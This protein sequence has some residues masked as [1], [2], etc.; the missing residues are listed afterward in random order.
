MTMRAIIAPAFDQAL[1][2]LVVQEVERP[3]PEA[4]EVLIRVSHAP[5]NPAD[6]MMI[7]GTYIRGTT[8]PF[9]PGLVGIGDVVEAGA[10]FMARMNKGKRVVFAATKGKGG[11]WAEYAVAPA[12]LC[13]PL[14]KDISDET[15][16][17]LLANASTAVALAQQLDAG[18]HKSAIITGAAGELASLLHDE[19]GKRGGTLIGVVRGEHQVAAL[20]QRGW[21][22]IVDSTAS[23]ADAALA[24]AVQRLGAKAAIDTVAGPMTERLMEALPDRSL[25][26][27]VG[28]LSSDKTSFDPMRQLIGRGIRFQGFAIDDWFADRN[29]LGQLGAVRRATALL[30]RHP[31]V[32]PR[33]KLSLD[34]AVAQLPELTAQ[35]GQGKILILPGKAGR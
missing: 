3:T 33:A 21:T 19:Y 4:G 34:Q 31:P 7:G 11:T 20:Q 5:V 22:A 35:G 32:P 6:V 14:P 13:I 28:R 1:N 24:S 9:S 25:I 26:L 15:G 18:G 2:G 27:S 17:N 10:G 30:K 16:V 29:I 12:G 23:G 8:V